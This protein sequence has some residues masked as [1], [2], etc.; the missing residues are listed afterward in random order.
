V[1]SID[2]NNPD[3]WL[4]VLLLP[5]NDQV[6]GKVKS[7]FGLLGGIPKPETRLF[8]NDIVRVTGPI[9]TQKYRDDNIKVYKVEEVEVR[10]SFK[11]CRFKAQLPDY[12]TFAALQ[13]IFQENGL[14]ARISWV[15]DESPLEW[16][17][18]LCA[19]E[20]TGRAEELLERFLKQN[21][22]ARTRDLV[23]CNY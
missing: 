22:K 20:T 7:G 8:F 6:Y 13:I 23:E 3:N 10:S 9:G 17:D 18:C 16:K 11:T 12:R 1:N 5:E 21:K 2:W 15:N 14:T 4:A 19:A